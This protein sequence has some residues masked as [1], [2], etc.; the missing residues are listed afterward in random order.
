MCYSVVMTVKNLTKSKIVVDNFQKFWKYDTAKGH[1]FVICY[2]KDFDSA[3]TIEIE[4]NHSDQVRSSD[5][6]WRKLK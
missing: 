1:K 5:G 6:R 2:G 4:L 3:K